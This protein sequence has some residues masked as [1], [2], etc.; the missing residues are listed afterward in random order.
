MV[1]LSAAEIG[2]RVLQLLSRL[3][4]IEREKSEL[5]GSLEARVEEAKRANVRALATAESRAA[6]LEE[7]LR[8]QNS[9]TS[10][11]FS[12]GEFGGPPAM[13]GPGKYCVFASIA[14]FLHKCKSMKAAEEK[15][16]EGI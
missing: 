12:N 14:H 11:S 3:D 1:W 13:A 9:G 2:K 10:G 6:V 7:E 16:E 4:A 15:Y 8:N 5:E